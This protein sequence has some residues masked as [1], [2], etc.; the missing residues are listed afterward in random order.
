MLSNPPPPPPPPP[1][2]MSDL[3]ARQRQHRRQNSTPTAYGRVKIA[4][5]P[6]KMTQTALRTQQQRARVAHR[7][8]MSLDTRPLPLF[9]TQQDFPTT[10]SH[11]NTTGLASTPQ[12]VVREAQQQRT[13]CPG[14]QQQ[15]AYEDFA[16]GDPYLVSPSSTPQMPSFDQQWI[17]GLP[18]LNTDIS[19]SFDM[20]HDQMQTG[21]KK[22]LDGYPDGF[23][24]PDFEAFQ[25]SGLS[26]PTFLDFQDQVIGTPTWMSETD[27]ASSRRSSRRISNGIMDRVNKFESMTSESRPLTPSRQNEPDYFPLTPTDTPSG[28]TIKRLQPPH[29]FTEGYD[30]SSEETVKPVRQRMNR[31]SQTTVFDDMRQSIETQRL[32]PDMQRANTMP[33]STSQHVPDYLTFSHPH[34][35]GLSVDTNGEVFRFPAYPVSATPEYSEHASPATPNF[36]GYRGFEM[37]NNNNIAPLSPQTTTDLVSSSSPL[38]PPSCSSPSPQKP[39]PS[40]RSSGSHR[41]TESIASQVSAASIASID[42]EKTKT[43]TGI[44]PDD[45]QQFIQGPSGPDNKWV[46][47]FESCGKRFGRK[48]NIKSHVQ[49]HLNDRQFQCPACRKCFVRQHDLKRHAKIHTGIKPYPCECGNSFAR[50]DALTRHRQRGMCVGAFEG[51]V[52]KNAK[53]GRPRKERP[54][55]EER[56]EK[57]ARTRRRRRGEG[58]NLSVSSFASSS[59]S[60]TTTR[61]EDEDGLL[62]SSLSSSSV[63]S[64]PSDANIH[65]D[66]GGDFDDDDEGENIMDVSLGGTTMNPSNLIGGPRSSAAPMPSLV[67]LEHEEDDLGA[68]AVSS[69]S[70]VSVHSY[71]TLQSDIV[72]SEMSQHALPPPL[73]HHPLSSLSHHHLNLN[74]YHHH[75]HAHTVS[76]PCYSSSGSGS[77]FSI[78][79]S[80]AATASEPDNNNGLDVMISS[81]SVGD[82]DESSTLEGP[83]EGHQILLFSPHNHLMFDPTAAAKFGEA[84]DDDD[85]VGLFADVDEEDG[86]ILGSR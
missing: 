43:E 35:A 1:P 40:K 31:R 44:T 49:T 71:V 15:Q 65:R 46:C 3:H 32:V 33:T 29:R 79:P 36:A 67:V 82:V 14:P 10:V 86:L 2:S 70:A 64:S 25:P 54:T 53:R 61:S 66:G 75:H 73:H 8:G 45:I 47:S 26:T 50:H 83:E 12:H 57:A 69:P 4:P 85:G 30:E 16:N 13:A 20:Y 28:A 59:A 21:M 23:T 51:S 6:S 41:R 27:A 19:L 17:D 58:A 52:P 37:N 22:S 80:P 42:I 74:A 60:T 81:S 84:Y 34:A 55:T 72:G 78:A 62:S 77:S 5:S 9:Q 11:T 63:V 7:R 39:P 38:P 56:R 48:E 18:M 68:A 24:C 76:S